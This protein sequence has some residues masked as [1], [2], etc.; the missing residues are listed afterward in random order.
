LLDRSL[1]DVVQ[2][3]L[4]EQWSHRPPAN[5]SKVLFIGIVVGDTGKQK[6]RDQEP[7]A[8]T[9]V[10]RSSYPDTAVGSVRRRFRV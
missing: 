2:A 3:K 6:A 7:G 9:A 8:A 5:R 1:F 10:T 4:T